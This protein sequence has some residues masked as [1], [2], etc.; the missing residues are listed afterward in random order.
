M[1]KPKHYISEGAAVELLKRLFG[2][3]EA[4]ALTLKE[5]YHAAGRGEL[6]DDTNRNWL[7]TVMTKLRYHNLITP[8]YAYDGRKKVSRIKLTI[9]GRTLLGRT[10]QPIT[11][12]EPS[13]TGEQARVITPQTVHDDIEILKKLY[14]SFNVGLIFEPKD[15]PMQH[16]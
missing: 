8:E 11:H 10:G 12:E 16:A 13:S 9:A 1:G 15:K 6:D 5:V 14:P 3:S 7:N 4:D 2:A